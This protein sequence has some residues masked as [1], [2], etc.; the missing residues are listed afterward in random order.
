MLVQDLRRKAFLFELRLELS[1]QSVFVADGSDNGSGEVA[2]VKEPC[3]DAVHLV[4]DALEVG[5]AAVHHVVRGCAGRAMQLHSIQQHIKTRLFILEPQSD[6]SRAVG[7]SI[8]LT[9]ARS[10]VAVEHCLELLE[11]KV[12]I[13]DDGLHLAGIDC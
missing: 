13:L 6:S 12:A 9:A 3:G 1:P 7:E 2:T 5:I 11:C 8:C 4:L 10:I